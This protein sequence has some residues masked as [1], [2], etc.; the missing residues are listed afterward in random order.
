MISES[1]KLHYSI[2]S[3]HLNC[4]Y[5]SKK[6]LLWYF[7]NSQYLEVCTKS[8][9]KE[10]Q[11]LYSFWIWWL[12]FPSKQKQR[13]QTFSFAWHLHLNYSKKLADKKFINPLIMTFLVSFSWY[14]LYHCTFHL[15]LHFYLLCRRI[16]SLAP[17]LHFYFV[18]FNVIQQIFIDCIISQDVH[19]CIS[20]S[21][22]PPCQSWVLNHLYFPF[23]MEENVNNY[24]K[25]LLHFCCQ[26]IN[27]K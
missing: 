6:I 25:I 20:L 22:L 26:L 11:N 13:Q 21:L 2:W 8:E 24:M 4:T 9:H 16:L 14:L 10:A 1:L 17:K 19:I 3:L 27:G 12:F 18:D 15:V 7:Y 5:A 23:I